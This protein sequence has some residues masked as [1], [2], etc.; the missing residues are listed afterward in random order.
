MIKKTVKK[1]LPKPLAKA[2]V[3][4]Y[5]FTEAF[6]ASI[7]NGFPARSMRFVGVTGTKGKT[8]TTNL[9]ASILEDAGMSV[10]MNST[11]VLQVG[12]QK[13]ENDLRLTT[14]NPFKTQKLFKKMKQAG[15]EIVA[16]EVSSHALVQHRVWGINFETTVWTNLQH[17]HLDYH[18]T[19]EDYAAAKARLFAHNPRLAILNAD[20]DWIDYFSKFPAEQKLLFG[21]EAASDCSI[22]SAKLGAKGSVLTLNLC[23][24]ELDVKLN[25]PGKFNAMNALAAATCAYGMG[26]SLEHIKSGLE[27]VKAV[28][29]RMEIID[30]GQEATVI[31]DYAHT[32][33][34]LRNILE[35]IRMSLHGRLIAVV[36]ADGERDSSKRIPIGKIAAELSEVVIV[37]DQEPYGDDPAPIRSEVIEGILE[38]QKEKPGVIYKE[39][40]DRRQAI[41][42]ALRYGKKGDVV[43]V[44]GIGNQPYR[45]T[46]D[47]KIDWDDR[48][49]TREEIHKI[50]AKS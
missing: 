37:A 20:D 11:A 26:I 30:E 29:G 17:D 28:P 27:K 14:A 25:L 21:V 22:K 31:V 15:C 13:W 12:D 5:H 6:A 34:S 9:I 42:Q 47:G 45:G 16:M 49:V 3:N 24:H 48:K 1:L 41:N 32:E 7:I 8:T 43:L 50:L 39:I 40:A 23:G 18:H 33:E 35:T 38:I 2:L 19:M 46:N 36:G 10:G 4:P 44:S